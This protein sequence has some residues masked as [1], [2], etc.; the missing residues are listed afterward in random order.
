MSAQGAALRSAVKTVEASAVADGFSVRTGAPAWA[1]AEL[2]VAIVTSAAKAISVMRIIGHP[3]DTHWS[4]WRADGFDAAIRAIQRFS[5]SA[6]DAKR[7]SNFADLILRSG[8]KDRVSKDGDA[9]TCSPS[10]ETALRASSG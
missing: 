4:L 5:E 6:D 1:R 3:L 2:A 10:F 8:P 9:L 7:P